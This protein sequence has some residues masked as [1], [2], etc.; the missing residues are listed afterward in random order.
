MFRI[1]NSRAKFNFSF[2]VLFAL[3]LAFVSF[4]FGTINSS[5]SSGNRYNKYKEEN[6]NASSDSSGEN[7]FSSLLTNQ[8]A[9]FFAGDNFKRTI[10]AGNKAVRSTDDL[11]PEAT[12]SVNSSADSNDAAPGNGACADAAGSCTLRAAVQ[13]ANALAG[14]DTITF[15][16][17]A[18]AVI[19]LTLGELSV[20]GNI[21]I[22]GLGARNLTVRRSAAAGTSNFRVFNISG[23]GV[24]AN[25]SG[26]TVA[27]GRADNGGGIRNTAG[28]TLNLTAVTVRDN[29]S[30][31]GA[32]IHNSGSLTILNSTVSNNLE[33]EGIYNGSFANIANSTISDN[34]GAGIT[35]WLDARLNN[36]TVSNN[37][38]L[39]IAVFGA[40]LRNTIVA[41]NNG[42]GADLFQSQPVSGGNNLIGK[43]G[44]F[45]VF[46]N[47]VNGDKVGT[48]DNP[49]NPL[50]GP[51]QN[52]G[53][54]TDTRMLL[55]G[56]P[57]FDSGNNC[58]VTATCPTN[59]PPAA[60][61]TDQRGLPRVVGGTIDI[62]AVE[63]ETVCS[64][65]SP[66]EQ[67]ISA[68]GGNITV[69]VE[70]GCMWTAASNASWITV[71]NGAT[72]T[73]NGTVTLSVQPNTSVARTGTVT[74]A[75]QTF[76]VNQ[77]SG[78]TYIL[79]PPNTNVPASGANGSFNV[80]SGNGCSWT[81]TSNVS[82]ISVTSNSNGSGNG[83]VSFSVRA[84]TGIARVGTITVGDQL[85]TVS[86]ANGCN[87]VVTTTPLTFGDTG[88]GGTINVTSGVGCIW[89][90][91]SNAPWITVFSTGELSGNGTINF[92]V[93]A[94]G[95]ATRTGTITIAGQTL[96]VTQTAG[97]VF[98]L[99]S[100]GVS[101]S[102]AGGTGS[103]SVTTSAGCAWSAAAT[104][105]WITITSG[106]SGTGNGTVSFTVQP[107]A[108]LQRTGTI[109]VNG[110]TFTVT[111]ASGCSYS[112]SASSVNVASGG[113]TGSF[114]LNTAPV[115]SWTAQSN[116]SWISITS[117]TAGTGTA[118]I[119]F[120]V[121]PNTGP[122]RTGTITAG[123]QTFTVNQANGCAFSLSTASIVIPASGGGGSFNF[124]GSD[125]CVWTAA[126]TAP[127]ITITT[128][129]TGTGSG[130]VEFT[131]AANGGAGRRATINLGGQTFTVFQIA[132]SVP[133]DFDGDG[134]ADVSIYRPS[135]NRWFEFFISS[136]TV[137]EQTF[138]TTGDVLAPAD[139]D[140][141]GRTDLGIFRPSTGDWWY[142]SSIDNTQK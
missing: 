44:G 18:P 45:N 60:L 3:L 62:G 96:T 5:A 26:I 15:D 66:T 38:G 99:E 130:S 121:Q 6:I 61:T 92:S 140:G 53:G 39:G 124:S 113:G 8:T 9:N 20:S 2:L 112:L 72:G 7:I 115:C 106:A 80:T 50:L 83:T 117:N 133:F 139:F 37:K 142:L 89:S 27:N 100:D 46:V 10:A 105:P 93:A 122:A 70:S 43:S 51:L 90:A 14:N 40:F 57:A 47:G 110:Q 13:E 103:L 77:L 68:A 79:S 82:W 87:F 58:V 85:F 30:Q 59:N 71:V 76:T 24:T 54:P 63:S 28:N 67:Q 31:S 69:N 25:I 1:I 97:C 52:N 94:N 81:A 48:V 95:G 120:A 104:V 107:N 118:A 138:G 132:K 42:T 34:D 111:Q 91:S 131:V 135:T 98:T 56:S 126:S 78:C 116:V 137:A 29:A 41:N 12:F 119:N 32:G 134:R 23:S 109:N 55:P 84:N 17:T 33:G 19:N 101:F 74:I 75:G 22:T 88:G 108:G 16:L 36:V 35:N 127:W 11:S 141:D 123:G 128:P 129:P 136:S 125:G 49:I 86:Q 73:G 64:T 4:S 65:F 21:T 102:A 114:N